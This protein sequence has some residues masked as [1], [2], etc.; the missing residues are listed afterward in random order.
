[1]NHVYVITIDERDGYISILR[2]RGERHY[3]LN[4][5]RYVKLISVLLKMLFPPKVFHRMEFN[6]VWS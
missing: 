6:N 1:M 3:C 2:A 5:R 4:S